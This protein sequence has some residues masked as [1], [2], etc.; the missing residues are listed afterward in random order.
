M[1][2]KKEKKT[3]EKQKPTVKPMTKK[4]IVDFI[5]TETELSRKDVLAVLDSLQNAIAK[6]LAKRGPGAFVLP[7]LLKIYKKRIPA[8]KARKNVTNPFTGE[9]QDIP[10]K[11][12]HDTVKI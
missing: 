2:A 6:G 9:V 8:K 10:S 4:E 7:G 11:P 1:A 12:A 5:M 3:A